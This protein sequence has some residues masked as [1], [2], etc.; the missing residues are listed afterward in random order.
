MTTSVRHSEI[1]NPNNAV[2]LP[3]S[4]DLVRE[5]LICNVG[6]DY[7]FISIQRTI[8]AAE[9]AAGVGTLS[10]NADPTIGLLFAQFQGASIKNIVSVNLLKA[11]AAPTTP[12]ANNAFTAWGWA[13]GVASNFTKLGTRIVNPDQTTQLGYSSSYTNL[14]MLDFGVNATCRVAA[15]DKIVVLLELGNS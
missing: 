14:F 1:I 2:I 7:S 11:I 3:T 10:D 4:T 15:G 12:T 9:I 8:Q 5:P 6:Q 13:A